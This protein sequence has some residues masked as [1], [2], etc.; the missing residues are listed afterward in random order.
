[1]EP[2]ILYIII[3]ALALLLL[4]NI[5][6]TIIGNIKSS[7]ANLET[8]KQSTY[9][10]IMRE[11]LNSSAI[12]EE[13]KLENIRTA[14]VNS[15]THMQQQNEQKLEEMRKT[16]DSKLQETLET[17]LTQSFKLVSE[18]LEEVHKG[19]GEMRSLAVGVGDLK[20]VLSNVKTN[21]ILGEY[22]LGAIL[23]EILSIEQYEENVITVPGSNNR[24]EYAIKLPNDNH[25]FV[26]L[27]IDSKFPIKTYQDLLQA[28]ET[29]DKLTIEAAQK[30]LISTMK[31]EA[32]DI[33]DKYIAVPHTT[34]FAIM[35]LPIEGLYCQ[36][37]QLGLQ[38][39]LQREYKVTIAGPSNMAA[40][41]NSLQMGFKTLAIQQR[42]AE[43]WKLLSSV[44]TEFGKFE[45]V[46]TAAQNRIQQTSD[47]LDKLVGTRTRAINKQLANIQ[48][49]GEYIEE[50]NKED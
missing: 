11:Q 28:F 46:L 13:Q 1:M 14:L 18:Q 17:K 29:T 5:V 40:L 7:K 3:A 9:L 33:H 12:Q 41:L 20:K 16:V 24:V 38:E 48:S 27:P 45:E 47:E 15:L 4:I 32:K 42:S 21:G 43:V 49:S 8:N 34:E 44:K 6:L 22:Q 30:T 39:L 23:K 2:T 31:S 36:A 26:Y 37:C 50:K 10:E 25:T 19:L 35:F